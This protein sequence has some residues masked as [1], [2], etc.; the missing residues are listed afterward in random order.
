MKNHKLS[1]I[2]P[3]Y[4][5][6]ELLEKLLSTIPK[7]KNIEV[8]VVDDKSEDK[9]INYI[10]NIQK[11]KEYTDFILLKNDTS[12]KSAG[13]ARNIGLEKANGEWILFADADDYFIENFYE[14]ISIYFESEND[15]LFFQPTSVYLD[16]GET[17]DRHIGYKNIL[18]NYISDQNPE[19]ELKVRYEML[20]PWAKMIQKEFILE[21][22]IK[23]DEVIASNDVMF[24]TKVGFH[25]KKF[26][27]SENI[28]YVVTKN[29][30]SL[31][32][33]LSEH[34]FDA[35]FQVSIDRYNFLKNKLSKE[36]FDLFNLPQVTRRYIVQS[37]KYGIVKLFGTLIIIRKN[38]IEF[39]HYN[40]LNPLH[41]LNKTLQ[42]KKRT[43]EDE[44]YAVIKNEKER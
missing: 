34:I 23:F 41:L 1:I 29:K 12:T 8:I 39:F 22:N 9:H 17:A 42:Y 26:K 30:G 33:N 16:T 19:N 25:M 5:S 4:N 20:V 10:E 37:I 28:L 11:S 24:S 44:K 3:H 32:T 13:T 36:N 6:S 31:T 38:N 27:I 2:I 14:S 35:R 40:L 7:D 18:E 21:N 15:V 43:K